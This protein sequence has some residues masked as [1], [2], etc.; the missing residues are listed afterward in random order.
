[1]RRIWTSRGLARAQGER[2]LGPSSGRVGPDTSDSPGVLDS[3][4]AVVSEQYYTVFGLSCDASVWGGVNTSQ[5]WPLGGLHGAE[6]DPTVGVV[7][8]GVR[9]HT[10]G[11]DG[12]CRCSPWGWRG[13]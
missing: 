8:F 7:Q 9:H 13:A 1:M 5:N 2:P 4:G 12:L 11:G 3:T 10:L 6:S